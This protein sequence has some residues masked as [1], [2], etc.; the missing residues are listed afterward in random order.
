[1][2]IELL[3]IEEKMFTIYYQQMLLPKIHVSAISSVVQ[4]EAPRGHSAA[5]KSEVCIKFTLFS[6]LLY[7]KQKLV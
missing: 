3:Y 7:A 2:Q 5:Q 6:K 4:E 1:M